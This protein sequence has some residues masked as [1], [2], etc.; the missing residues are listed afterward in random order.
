MS[1][2]KDLKPAYFLW[3]NGRPRWEPGPRLR[4][5][6][7]GVDLKNDAGEW[8]S[9]ERAI[10][11]ANR[12]N[13]EVEA[14]KAGGQ[15][16][17]RPPAARKNPRSCLALYEIWRTS[18]KFSRL[19]P[20]TRLDYESKARIFL[21]EFG[22]AHVAE[23]RKPHLY[24]WWEEL[25][26]Q[27]GHP[28]ANGTVA[29][30]RVMLSH[31]ARIGWRDDNPARELGLDGVAPRQVVWLPAEINALVTAADQL[32]TPS[33]GDA[34]IV[35]LHTSQRQGDVLRLPIRIFDDAKIRLSHQ[36]LTLRQSKRQALIDAPMT[37]ACRERVQAIKERRWKLGLVELDGP[38]ILREDGLKYDKWSF[39]RAFRPARALAAKTV[40][41][42]VDKNFQDLR[43]TAVTR[44]ALADCK[45]PEI[46]AIT[47]HS[48]ESII[49]II[50]H[51]LVLQPEMADSAISKLSTWLMKEEIAL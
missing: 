36:R 38:L 32:G 18:S 17:R 49:T 50:K 25:Q 47:G 20:P 40:P 45:M 35:A 34:V 29:V 16:R 19:A 26:S 10:G 6:W 48:A 30:A 21:A 2:W 23:I 43:D 14:W 8:L 41:T 5:H 11:E 44:L 7:K 15:Q 9:I 31:A 46:A 13:G 1:E 28:M 22:H 24:R 39:G 42:I 37:P 3:R 12:I 27:R 51:Y 4:P 33:V